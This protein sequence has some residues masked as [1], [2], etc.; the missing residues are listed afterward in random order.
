ML[1]KTA[2][3]KHLIVLI[4]KMDDPTV[5]WDVRRYEECRD[6]LLPFLKQVGFNPKTDIFVMPC[7]GYQGSN[8][9][10]VAPE[11]VCPWYRG[12]SFI[13]YLDTL[14][15]ISRTAEGPV[16]IPIIDRYRD[17]G[18]VLIGKIE[19]GVI[20]RGETLT[21]MPNKEQVSGTVRSRLTL[22]H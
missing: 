4:N 8:L 22:L 18:T 13:D 5:A 7:S 21:M 19:S 12:P 2:G 16:R 3:V 1:V 11:S 10:E 15:S 20:A 9:K 6:K 17:M 14:P